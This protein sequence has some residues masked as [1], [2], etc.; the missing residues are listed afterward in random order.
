[1]PDMEI[2]YLPAVVA[3]LAAFALGALWYGPLFGKAWVRAHG[4]TEEEL[5][6]M[7][8]G[9]GKAYLSALVSNLIMAAVLAVLAGWSGV[10]TVGQTMRL[11]F[12]CWLGFVLTTGLTGL[13][14]SN[15]RPATF[16]IDAGY[17]LIYMLVMGAIIG[18]WR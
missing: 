9:A 7:R 16:F 3:A 4:Y 12:L 5:S 6:A 1:M 14:F 18:G 2:D 11:A 10:T 13:A 8:T 17:Q 15:R